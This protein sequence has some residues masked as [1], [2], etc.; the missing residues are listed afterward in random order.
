M[1]PFTGSPP[2]FFGTMAFLVAI[3][4]FIP[5][6]MGRETIGQLELVTETAS[7]AA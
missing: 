3:G 1:A 6:I 4:A 5:P 2:I 7:G